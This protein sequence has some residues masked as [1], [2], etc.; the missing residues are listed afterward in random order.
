VAGDL[1]PLLENWVYQLCSYAF[2]NESVPEVSAFVLFV[3]LQVEYS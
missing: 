3:T 1:Y 2:K